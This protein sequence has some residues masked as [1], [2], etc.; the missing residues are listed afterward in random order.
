VNF[1]AGVSAEAIYDP[2]DGWTVGVI[3]IYSDQ[4]GGFLDFLAANWSEIKP[5][6]AG[7]DIVVGV[8][9][10]ANAYGAGAT[11]P[12][13]LAYA[14]SLGITILP[15]EE[16]AVSPDADVTG[17]LQNLMLEGANVIYNQNLSFSVAQVVGTARA[18]GIW[19]SIVMGG[20]SWSGNNDVLNFLG[21]NVGLMVGYYAMA[22][23]ASWSD[24][25]NT[26]VQAAAAAFEAGGYPVT[27]RTNTYLLTYGGMYNTVEI[28]EHAINLYGWPVTG[29]TFFDAFKDLGSVNSIG[30]LEYVATADGDRA[31]TSSRVA[32]LQMVDGEVR[33]V[34]VAD[35]FVLPDLR[36]IAP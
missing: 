22:P 4:F 3:P 34:V 10:W 18:L 31:P 11:T 12:E 35:W 33:Y 32:Q 30:I 1:A 27:D 7:D 6:G 17:Q 14:E 8:I 29:D 19:D 5:E 20:V 15:L 2:A 36:P 13:A 21:E 23:H 24:T 25:D 16:Q 26:G 28:L 9:G